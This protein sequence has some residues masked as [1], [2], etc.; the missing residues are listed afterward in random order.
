LFAAVE[1]I[2]SIVMS[3][4]G[5]ERAASTSRL[6]MSAR[7]ASMEMFVGVGI[8]LL[9]A[10]AIILGSVAWRLWEK[11]RWV[12]VLGYVFILGGCYA[13]SLGSD[14]AYLLGAGNGQRYFYVAN[15]VFW[16]LLLQNIGSGGRG[17]LRARRIICAAVLA[18]G[19]IAG[20]QGY[21]PM[22]VA[23]HD[24]PHWPAEVARWRNDST[25]CLY[26]APVPWRMCLDAAHN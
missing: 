14:K 26:I 17:T 8:V 15:V 10:E 21:R 1:W 9:V 2:Q 16:L 6:I 22:G 4:L 3:L 19:L 18:I 7:A 20:M 23:Q 5:L 25:Y 12:L 11:D 13:F 24:W